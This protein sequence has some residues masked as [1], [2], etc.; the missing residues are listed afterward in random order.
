MATFLT[1][2][3]MNPALAA[4]IEASVRGRRG[5]TVTSRSA[6]RF[7]SILRLVAAVAIALSIYQLVMIRRQRR[8][9]VEHLRSG[10]LATVHAHADAVGPNAALAI[11]RA[12]T[13]L[14]KLSGTYE[15]ELVDPE[16]TAPDAFASLLRRPLLYVRGSVDAFGSASAL[17]SATAASLKD[18][19]VLCL[20]E[21]PATRTETAL[22]DKVRIAYA[23]GMTMESRTANVHR[24]HEAVVGLPLLLPAWSERVAG[25]EDPGE[26]TRL[27]RELERAPLEQAKQAATAGLFLVAIDED[28]GASGPTELDGE[29]PHAI[30]VALVDLE[31]SKPLLRAR[32]S[33]DPNWISPTRRP[34]YA[35]GLDGCALAFDVHEAVRHARR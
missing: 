26:L 1:T 32:R 20:V 9:E 28:G 14:A 22:L 23:G 27:R 30:R 12:A 3:K 13:W 7:S 19:I 2:S 6:R 8:T 15:G 11:P 10:I 4:R 34:T 24:L 33:V 35:R 18:P 5:Q 21:P 31:R 29:R 25:A 17:E 16:L